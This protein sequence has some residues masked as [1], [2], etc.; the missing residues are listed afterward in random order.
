M[1]RDLSQLRAAQGRGRESDDVKTLAQ[2]IVNESAG[3][4][5]VVHS[6]W[7]RVIEVATAAA[8]EVRHVID[9]VYTAEGFCGGEGRADWSCELSD[10][11]RA[12]IAAFVIP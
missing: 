11:Q 2:A 6:G 8:A 3:L 10:N 9:V 4:M 12:Q 7:W 5:Y 1:V